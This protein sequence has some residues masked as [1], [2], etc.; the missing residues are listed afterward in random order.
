MGNAC[1]A[2]G[3]IT[4]YFRPPFPP[5]TFSERGHRRLAGRLKLDHV[6]N[7]ESVRVQDAFG[8]A[9]TQDASNSSAR[10]RSGLMSRLWCRVG[11]VRCLP[12]SHR[13]TVIATLCFNAWNRIWRWPWRR[14]VSRVGPSLTMICA[15]STYQ[16]PHETVGRDQATPFSAWD[17]LSR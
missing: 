15:T 17:H 3:R 14:C 5:P 11:I 12:G 8:A 16:R 4:R 7:R 6:V 9:V 10:M 1:I 13:L 2:G